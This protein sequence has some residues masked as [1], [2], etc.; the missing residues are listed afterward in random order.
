MRSKIINDRR[1]ESSADL[2][3]S[4][5]SHSDMSGMDLNSVK[6][7]GTNLAFSD[8]SNTTLDLSKMCRAQCNGANFSGARMYGVDMSHGDFCANFYGAIME[9]CYLDG[10]DFTGARGLVSLGAPYDWQVILVFQPSGEHMIGAGCRWFTIWKAR[11]HWEG[12]RDRER[13]MPLLD[14]AA[15]LCKMHDAE[16]AARLPARQEDGPSI[17]ESSHGGGSILESGH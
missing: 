8:L 2:S 15:A 10:A 4:D 14:Y 1:V 11:D 9:D 3:G 17:L 12:R 13:M 7:S 6:L 5:L 16:K